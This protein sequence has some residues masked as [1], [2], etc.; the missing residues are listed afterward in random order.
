M[1]VLYIMWTLKYSN[2]PIECPKASALKA[3]KATMRVKAD[4]LTRIVALKAFNLS[5]QT[6]RTKEVGTQK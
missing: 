3:F 6:C 2:R 5:S 4:A 1:S